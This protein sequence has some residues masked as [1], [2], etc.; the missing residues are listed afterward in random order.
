[1]RFSGRYLAENEGGDGIFK[2]VID[3]QNRT[4]IGAQALGNYSSEFI[5]LCGT[6]IELKLPLADI[7][8]IV[9]PHPA[10]CEIIREAVSR[11]D[12]G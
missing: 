2:L 8:K 7:S 1:M 6:F 3:K 5:V 12:A 4:V 11:Y 9:F 10:V